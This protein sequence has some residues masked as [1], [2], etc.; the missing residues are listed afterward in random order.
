[1]RFSDFIDNFVQEISTKPLPNEKYD[2]KTRSIDFPH[3][4]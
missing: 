3:P 2:E 4:V 1:M